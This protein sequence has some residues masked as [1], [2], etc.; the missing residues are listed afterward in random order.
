[1]ENVKIFALGGQD[2]NG[3]NSYVFSYND[4]LYIINSGVKI[5]INSKNGVDTLIPDF[6][7]LEKNKDKIKGIFIT[8]IRNESFSALPWLLMKV[9]NARIYT[10]FLNKHFIQER[11]QKYNIKLDKFQIKTITERTKIGSIVVQP[12]SLPGST[13]GNLG[14]DFITKSGDYLF[15]FN[16]VEGDLGIFGKTWFYHLSKAFGKRKLNAIISDAG[17]SKT[18]GKAI[19]KIKLP[20]YI[21]ESFKKSNSKSRIV[22]G[23]YSEDV[24]TLQ[25]V[26]ELAKKYNRPIIP[27]GKN[28]ADILFLTKQFLEKGYPEYQFPEILD[29]KLINK[30]DNAVV[31]VTGSIERLYSRFVR[32]VS[33]DDVYMKINKQ[34]TVIMIAP[35]VNGLESEAAQTLDEIAKVTSNLIDVPENEYFYCRPSREDIFSLIK[36]LKPNYFIPA[37]G[38]YR[39]LVDICDYLQ[40]ENKNTNSIVLLNGKI[41]HFENGKLISHNGRI[42]EIGDT[43]IDGFGVGD[44]SSEVLAEREVLGRDGVVI[45]N[46]L[47]SPK[48]KKI[49]GKLH[50]NYVGVINSDEYSKF[51]RLIKDIIID[52]ISS[53]EYANM[54]EL[55][56]RVRKTIRKK[57]FKL[58]DKD[59]MVAF[60]L[61]QVN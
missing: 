46:S 54:R 35:P 31:L 49:I 3:K 36:N 47:Y 10:S 25:Q 6:T 41:A 53:K 24:A 5:P 44:I 28:Y 14:F 18:N 4:D 57:I 1:M 48:T 60:T 42:K 59:P 23:A 40:T 26:I 50:I 30:T 8:D 55:N 11:L 19:D 13:P 16:Y 39:Y 34:D 51:D 17:R 58:T 20:K 45:I 52:L 15:M 32:I 7:F 61:T 37:Q 9:P 21:E 43:I 27:Y 2:E 12:I 56:E 38:L 33:N 22:I 29:Y